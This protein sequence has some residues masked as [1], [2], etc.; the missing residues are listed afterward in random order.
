MPLKLKAGEVLEPWG[1]GFGKIT[2]ETEL[3]QAQLAYLAETYPES[4]EEEA[5]AEEA[6][7]EKPKTK[8]K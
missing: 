7:E 3:S 4:F 1:K 8:K 2:E 5:P 6:G